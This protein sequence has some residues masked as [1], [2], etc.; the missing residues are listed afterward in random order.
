[1]LAVWASLGTTGYVSV[2]EGSGYRPLSLV[3][4]GNRGSSHRL[5]SGSV[6]NGM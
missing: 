3:V 2:D 4:G 1:M 5:V 6:M